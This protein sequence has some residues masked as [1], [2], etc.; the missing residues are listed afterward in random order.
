VFSIGF[1][2]ARSR[3]LL[4][5]ILREHAPDDARQALAKRV[6][7]HLERSNFELDEEGKALRQRPP[8]DLH[9]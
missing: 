7:D 6:L 2:I 9:G 3:D 8:R 1:A 4:R 5:R